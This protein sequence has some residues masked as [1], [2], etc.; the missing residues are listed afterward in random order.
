MSPLG[1]V[2]LTVTPASLSWIIVCPAHHDRGAHRSVEQ[3]RA[4]LS[5]WL[6]RPEDDAAAQG[7]TQRGSTGAHKSLVG[8][9]KRR[10]STVLLQPEVGRHWLAARARIG[11]DSPARCRVVYLC[12]WLPFRTV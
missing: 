6:P 11:V 1:V 12:T 8:M 3:R 5:R 10:G 2:L 9:S 7:A 4:R